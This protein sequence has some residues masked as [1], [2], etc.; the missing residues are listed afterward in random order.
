MLFRSD[1]GIKMETK[2]DAL[3]DRLL[4]IEELIK[5]S[6]SETNDESR[7]RKQVIIDPNDFMNL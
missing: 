5:E 4:R 1:I 2:F 3:N 7:T 6:R